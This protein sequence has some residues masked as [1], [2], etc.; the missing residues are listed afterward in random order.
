MFY[1]NCTIKGLLDISFYKYKKAQ[2]K[3]AGLSDKHL[4]SEGCSVIQ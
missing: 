2:A 4:S 1:K 3:P